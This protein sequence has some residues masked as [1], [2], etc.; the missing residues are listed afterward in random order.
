MALADFAQDS[1]IFIDANIFTYFAFTT[2][3]FLQ[4]KA[5]W[6]TDDTD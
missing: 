6:D 5:K 2:G 4:G 3:H 1:E